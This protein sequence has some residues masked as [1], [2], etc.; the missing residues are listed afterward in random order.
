MNPDDPRFQQWV[1][2]IE[3]FEGLSP[4]DAYKIYTKGM[5][6]NI[7]KGETVFEK[8][9]TGNSMFVLLGGLVGIF[10]GPKQIATMRTGE[11]FGEMSLL[12][13]EVRSATALVLEDS[14]M[15]MLDETV[16]QK[17]LT[18]KVAVRMLLNLG[19]MLAGRIRDGN[20]MIR[21]MEGR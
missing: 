12:S 4:S 16:F 3:L 19:N 7:Q 9:T 13:G 14:H 11:S 15:F 8:G 1:R 10:D 20:M 5:T 21:E 17:L 18:K 6:M 2:R